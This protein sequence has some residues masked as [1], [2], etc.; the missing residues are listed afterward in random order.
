MGAQNSDHRNCG[1]FGGSLFQEKALSSCMVIPLNQRGLKLLFRASLGIK[2][3]SSRSPLSSGTR[4][5]GKKPFM[6]TLRKNGACQH[7]GFP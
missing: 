3:S 4:R 6:K 2:A 5:R 7:Y 1:L